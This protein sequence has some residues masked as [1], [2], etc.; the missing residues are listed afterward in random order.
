MNTPTGSR[1]SNGSSQTSHDKAEEI[2][3][4]LYPESVPNADVAAR[5]VRFVQTEGDVLPASDSPLAALGRQLYREDVSLDRCTEIAATDPALAELVLRAANHAALGSRRFTVPY[6]VMF[7]GLARLRVL[8]GVEVLRR[9]SANALSR[10]WL[11]FWERNLFTARLAE[12][13]AAY[14]HPV[15]GTEYLAGLLHD[16]AWPAMVGFSRRE[17]GIDFDEPDAL[18]PLERDIFGTSHAAISAAMCLRSG[19]S[20]HVVEAV[21]RHHDPALPDASRLSGPRY[22]GAFLGLLIRIADMSAD[23]LGFP[24]DGG[25]GKAP[26]ASSVGDLLHSPE[27]HWLRSFGLPPNLEAMAT[28]ELAQ[29][30]KSWALF[31]DND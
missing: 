19:L 16:A 25:N 12:R 18:F 13:L 31:S 30:R 26:A 6:A 9:M 4:R 7:L 5:L 2:R 1:S 11:P 8:F 28:E 10:G 17:F 3:R 22:N 21:A 29:V 24:S 15:D 14:Y 23:A 27:L 20:P